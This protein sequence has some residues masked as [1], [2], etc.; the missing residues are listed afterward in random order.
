M[1]NKRI[2]TGNTLIYV[3][4]LTILILGVIWLFGEYGS[5]PRKV[6]IYFFKDHRIAFVPRTVPEKASPLYYTARQLLQ[7]PSAAEIRSGYF[8]QIP[9][10]TDIRT[11]SR[12]DRVVRADF[13]K[14]LEMN[15]G[16][17]SKVRGIIAQI[18]YTF[19]SIRGVKSVQVTVNGR[20]DLALGNEGY[21]IDKPLSRDDVK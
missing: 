9:K 7:G 4:G 16:G 20:K 12:E 8:T 1:K 19:T 2:R 17:T 11:I 10:G 15:G 3:L 14:D 6:K 5:S 21:V 13:T 18:V